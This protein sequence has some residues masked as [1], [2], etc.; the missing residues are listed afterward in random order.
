MPIQDPVKALEIARARAKDA[1]QDVNLRG[2]AAARET[3][4]L[5]AVVAGGTGFEAQLCGNFDQPIEVIREAHEQEF[6]QKG[7]IIEAAYV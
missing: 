4:R 1:L 5:A 7:Q 3:A 6:A 2:V